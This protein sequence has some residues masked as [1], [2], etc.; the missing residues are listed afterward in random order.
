MHPSTR[1]SVGEAFASSV[2]AVKPLGL[3]AAGR[4]SRRGSECLLG[5]IAVCGAGA[6]PL[7][8]RS[9]GFA[10]R[11][12]RDC[13]DKPVGFSTGS[14]RSLDLGRSASFASRARCKGASP[15]NDYSVGARLWNAGKPKGLT[16]ADSVSRWD[17]V[18]RANAFSGAA[19]PREGSASLLYVFAPTPSLK[20]VTPSAGESTA[21][22]GRDDEAQNMRDVE[23]PL[24]FSTHRGSE[25]LLGVHNTNLM[26]CI[27]KSDDFSTGTLFP[28]PNRMIRKGL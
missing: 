27:E 9:A 13:V 2:F 11:P 21:V 8:I 10:S 4:A 6:S 14:R 3:L 26:T 5:E 17:G 25:S 20:D 23:K 24:G 12:R 15:Y 1:S 19:A 22:N 18:S 16:A 28:L 7:S